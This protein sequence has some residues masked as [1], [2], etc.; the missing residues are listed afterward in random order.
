M[1]ELTFEQ[2]MEKLEQLIKQL[3]SG[4]NSLDASV[5]LYQEGIALA[6]ECHLELEQAEKT[7]LELRTEDGLED[8][9][10]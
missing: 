8:F 3:E 9:N 1:S 5:K 6:K 7:I 4:D 10:K 2:K